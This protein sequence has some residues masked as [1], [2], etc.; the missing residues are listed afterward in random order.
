MNIF[1]NNKQKDNVAEYCFDISKII[2]AI[3]VISPLVKDG[4]GQTHLVF[5]GITLVLF[6]FFSG[7]LLDSKEV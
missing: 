1:K 4:F 5:G 3:I 2:L 6:F 7:Y